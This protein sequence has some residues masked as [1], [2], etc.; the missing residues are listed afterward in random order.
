MSED[1]QDEIEALNAIY[2]PDTFHQLDKDDIYA[3]KIPLQS[4]TLR[5]RFLPDY[6]LTPPEIAGIETVGEITKKGYGNHVLKIARDILGRVWYEGEVC[7]YDLVQELDSTLEQEQEA[8]GGESGTA[9][10]RHGA[11]IEPPSTEQAPSNPPTSDIRS[12]SQ[13]TPTWTASSPITEKKSVFVAHACYI[14]SPTYFNPY[15]THLLSLDKKFEKATHN[16]TAYRIRVPPSIDSPSQ[17]HEIVYQDCDD[18][19]ETAAG[20]RLLHLLEVMEVWNVMVVV[21]RWYGGVNLGPDRFRLINTVAREV[22]LGV[23]RLSGGKE[24]GGGREGQG[25]RKK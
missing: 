13:P 3:L 25:R 11:A 24:G 10:T 15:L 21:S 6:P 8:E 12:P 14:P 9:E 1:L 17:T 16:I 23:G 4:V 22:V 18:D 20:G 7:M 5:L 19:G 2:S